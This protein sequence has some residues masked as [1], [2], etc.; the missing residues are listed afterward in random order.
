EE[1]TF[2]Y[3]VVGMA[4]L[5]KPGHSPGPNA[6]KALAN[7][8]ERGL[9]PGLIGCDRA[10]TGQKP[11][12]FRLPAL[13]LGHELVIDY[14]NTELGRQG[15]YG[16]ALL[17]DGSWYCPSMPTDL[18]EATAEFR[19]GLI[20]EA[21]WQ[22]RVKGRRSYVFRAKARP[23]EDGSQRLL[24]PAAGA[25]P[26]TRCP[27]KKKSTTRQTLGKTPI[28]LTADVEADPPA[29]CRQD[30]VTFPP[31][32]GDRYLQALPHATPE[33]H[34]TYASLRNTIEGLNGIVK[35]GTYEALADST[36]R[37]VRGVAAQ[38][39]LVAF[40]LFAV[41]LRKIDTFLRLAV[42]E[43][44]G[45]LRVPLK[46]RHKDPQI[47]ETGSRAGGSDPPNTG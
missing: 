14:K 45:T 6:I 43:P 40:G 21:L 15:S 13:A 23:D 38:S 16:G 19:A 2:P 4:P 18:I 29:V 28:V 7:M 32:A 5:H 17:V 3:L 33:W 46:R 25:A 26:T 30:S 10:Y 34:K 1:R 27:L 8:S 36:R 35:D 42:V 20:D 9:P 22:E 44:D 31:E 37:R 39:V 11:E 12:N 24:C 47:D 41:N